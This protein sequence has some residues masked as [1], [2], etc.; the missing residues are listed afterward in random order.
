M[1]GR[2][3]WARRGWATTLP[4]STALPRSQY[5]KP[6]V[7]R[8]DPLAI[9]TIHDSEEKAREGNEE[10]KREGEAD[11][12]EGRWNGGREGEGELGGQRREE[13]GVEEG[14]VEE[15]GEAE[16]VLR[17]VLQGVAAGE[18]RAVRYVV[19]QSV[20]ALF[21]CGMD[22]ASHHMLCSLL[23]YTTTSS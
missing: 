5:L 16:N 22:A 15:G 23:N 7:H 19:Q 18:R 6:L 21:G 2:G 1:G 3:Q 17:Q 20:R 9:H 12:W 4:R 8:P 13:G 10:S 14:G 11:R